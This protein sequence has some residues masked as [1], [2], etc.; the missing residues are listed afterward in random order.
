MYC[1]GLQE[2]R[3]H[4]VPPASKHFGEEL[5]LFLAFH[6][7]GILCEHMLPGAS[8][9]DCLSTATRV[10]GLGVRIEKKVCRGSGIGYRPSIASLFLV[11]AVR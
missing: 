4:S 3:T 11:Y 2:E 8:A 7:A 6:S 9:V 1:S 10:L 5:L